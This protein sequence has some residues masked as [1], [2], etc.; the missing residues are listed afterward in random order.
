MAA[1]AILGGKRT[2]ARPFP[3]WPQ[4]DE[5]ER[6]A[7]IEVLESRKWGTLGPKAEEL[8]QRFAAMVGV[9]RALAVT[10]GT[11]SLEIVLRALDVGPGDEVIVPP[12]TFVATATAPLLAGATPVFADIDLDTLCLDAAE[13]EAAVSERT[14]A[15]IAVHMAGR[16]ADMDA[17]GKVARSRG[18]ALVEDAAQ[19][20]GAAW[21]GRAAGS[22][23]AAGSFSFQLS[24]NMSA[25]EG[26]MITVG[27][28]G[29]AER[30]WSI[31]HCGRD[32]DGPWY[33]HP[34]LGGNDRMT[35][36][37]AA[38]LLAQMQRLPAQ[39]SARERA[40]RRLDAA[41]AGIDGLVVPPADPR[42]SRHAYHLYTFR[43][44]SERFDG[45]PREAF[46]R[47]LE[48]EGIPCSAGYTPLH[49]QG[50]F[51]DPRLQARLSRG[52]DYQALSLPACEQAC[53][54]VVWIPQHVLLGDDPDIDDVIAALAKVRENAAELRAAGRAG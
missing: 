47:A 31:R 48:A 15:I 23:G 14:R 6:A 20:H 43:Y 51:A 27:D 46:V 44:L 28:D 18:I 17:L 8:E 13:V 1:L 24:K 9:R 4:Y 53:R 37:Q 35:D 32:P 10:N 19:A 22:L 36:W 33:E 38:V 45:A 39:A 40:A 52:I 30:C 34:R 25:G 12:Y 7:L 21:R 11:A 2:R 54:E 29:L 16:P 50:L 42:V 41:L 3:P 5:R 49:R 26:G